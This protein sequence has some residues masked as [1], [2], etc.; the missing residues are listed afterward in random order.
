M[1]SLHDLGEFKSSFN[2]LGDEQRTLIEMGLSRDDLPLPA[3]EP[4]IIPDSSQEGEAEPR[5]TEFEGDTQ[6]QDTIDFG[7]LGDILGSMDS[8]NTEETAAMDQGDMDFGSFID[9]IPDNFAEEEGSG[10]PEDFATE[11]GSGEILEDF[12]LDELPAED[13]ASGELPSE[14]FSSEDFSSEDLPSDDFTSNDF[15][16]DEFASEDFSPGN[17][18]SEDFPSE[19]FPSEDFA[20]EDFASG[21]LPSDDFSSEDLPSNDFTSND[22][23]SEEFASEDFASNDFSS[24][25]FASEDFAEEVLEEFP[26]GTEEEIPEDSSLPTELLDGFADEIEAERIPDDDS[27]AE[28]LEAGD[29]SEEASFDDDFGDAFKDTGLGNIDLESHPSLGMDDSLELLSEESILPSAP[30]MDETTEEAFE[31]AAD[32]FDL[33][34]MDF[35]AASTAED[36]AETPPEAGGI[37]EGMAEFSDDENSFD[38]GGESQDFDSSAVLEEISGDSFDNFKLD[39]G[40]LSGNFDIGGEDSIDFGDGF[41]KLEDFSA[42]G[43]EDVFSGKSPAAGTPG[44]GWGY[45]ADEVEEIR[46]SNEDLENFNETLS[47]YPLNLRIACEELIAEQAVAPDLM[48]KLINL[49]IDGAPAKETA[50]LAGQILGK[51]ISIPRAFEKKT[52][53]ALEAEQSSF[54]YIFVHNFLPVFRLFLMVAMVLVSIG[55]LGWKFIYTPLRAERIYKLGYERIGAGEYGR[56]NERFLEA[57][58]IY[59]KK[60]WFFS[61]ARAFREVRQ[62]SLAEEKYEELLYFTASRNKRRIPDKTAVLEYADME[63]NVIGNYEKADEILR[64]NLLDYFPF[65]REGLLALGDNSL[66]WGE[67]EPSRMENAREYYATYMERYGRSDPLLERMLKYFIRTD[68]LGQVI[69]LQDHFMGTKPR[70][71]SSETLAELGGYYLDKRIEKIQGVPNEYL[72]YIGGIREILLRAIQQNS[73]LPESYYQLARYYNYFENLYDERLT[74]DLAVRVFEAVREENPKRMRYHILTLGRYGEVLIRDKEFFSA[75]ENLIKGINLFQDGLSRNLLKHSPEFGKLYA[76]LGDLEY[77]IKEGDMANALNYYRLGEEN[78]YAPPEIQYRMGAAHYQ[79][80]QWGPAQDRLY[81]AFRETQ[82]NRRILYALGNVS[83][84]R[85][86]YSAAQGYYDRLLEILED[87]RSRL[88]P[89]SPTNNESELDLAERLMV[90][91][92]NLGVALEG[93]TER[94]GNSRYRS[95]AQGLY[96]DSARAWDI[97]TRNPET[98]TR[99]LPAAGINA[100]GINPAYLNVQNNLHPVPDY[101]AHFFLRIDKDILEPSPWEDLA[102][103]GYKL[104]EGL[105]SGR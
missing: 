5:Q 75:E 88:P 8:E 74:L 9:S 27:L 19:D 104:S 79:L 51:T 49:L 40:A 43:I 14:D 94:T 50:S 55:Y 72:E 105:Y 97:L 86:N 96:S 70:P 81:S 42:Q 7:D 38:L 78:F 100:P 12:A 63:T 60:P 39:T 24:E 93:L 87:D 47:S 33:G 32:D 2:E 71:I 13:L 62:Y 77:F 57:F 92:N 56:A 82:P 58:K 30:S 103:F 68:D 36:F 69:S 37:D 66:I 44:K 80:R 90:V 61:Y 48:S 85:G 89:I 45:G 65:D 1:P 21:E 25:D 3:H 98:M 22:F 95:R 6:N 20:L 84:M 99:M 101:Q 102:P 29:F 23:S 35:S 52:G 16:S 73:M 4:A 46:L 76:D 53:E 64:Y 59:P 31:A 54:A 34:D 26:E 17:L 15:S 83:Y 28:D 67:Y 41:G 91:Q 11:E 18:P 10:E